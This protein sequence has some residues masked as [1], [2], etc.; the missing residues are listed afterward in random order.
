[1]KIHVPR[2][3]WNHFQVCSLLPAYNWNQ[4][5]ISSLNLVIAILTK[6]TKCCAL[7]LFVVVFLS[8]WSIL[9]LINLEKS[10]HLWIC[11]H[12]HFIDCLDEQDIHNL[13][14][15]M[16]YPTMRAGSIYW[17]VDI[18]G[19]YWSW[20]MG[21]LDIGIGYSGYWLNQV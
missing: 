14:C 8:I 19:W 18:F 1:M 5:D 11:V 7:M 15:P 3:S 21:K 6:L 17:L 16:S 2:K 20:Y 12:L 4:K 9:F 10:F 13:K